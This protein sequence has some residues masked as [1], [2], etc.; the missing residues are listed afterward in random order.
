[1]TLPFHCCEKRLKIQ[2]KTGLITEEEAIKLLAMPLTTNIVD[3]DPPLVASAAGR[4]ETI[5]SLLYRDECSVCSKQ[6]DFDYE[7]DDCET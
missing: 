1:M 4:L 2:V 7:Y 6:H 3:T 5:M